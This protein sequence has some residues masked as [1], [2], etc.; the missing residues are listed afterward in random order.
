MLTIFIENAQHMLNYV[1][2][3]RK[4]YNDD[5]IVI[6]VEVRTIRWN[7]MHEVYGRARKKNRIIV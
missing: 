1:H 7:D 3:N 4:V 5:N 2:V 6:F